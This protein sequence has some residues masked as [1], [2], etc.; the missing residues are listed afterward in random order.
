MDTKLKGD[1]AECAV[2]LYALQQGWGVLHPFG[3]RLPYDLV[4]D[5]DGVL[6]K[7]QVKS[8]WFDSNKEN[9]VVDNRRTKTN[10]RIMVRSNYNPADFDFA[11][12]YI[13]DLNVFY[14]MPSEIF[15]SYGSE[16]HL[17]ETD[18]RQR[19]PRSAEYRNAWKLILQRAAIEEI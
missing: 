17:V 8:A 1:I 7:V 4:L 12:L 2:T 18:K 15:I 13:E 5:I 16:I 11:V 10:R 9:Y 3:D 6:I 19:K 14:V